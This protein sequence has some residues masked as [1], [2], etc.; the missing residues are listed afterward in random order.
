MG[1]SLFDIMTFP[2]GGFSINLLSFGTGLDR[3]ETAKEGSFIGVA[4]RPD[5]G[6]YFDAFWADFFS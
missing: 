5:T 6:W 1:F 4:W 3:E 2:E